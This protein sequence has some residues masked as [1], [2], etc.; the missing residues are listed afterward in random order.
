MG[1]WSSRRSGGR[2]LPLLDDR[3]LATRARGDRSSNKRASSLRIALRL[4][5]TPARRPCCSATAIWPSPQG[6]LTGRS[7]SPRQPGTR[8][9]RGGRA[10]T[11][12]AGP[13]CPRPEH[14]HKQGRR[15]QTRT[16]ALAHEPSVTVPLVAGIRPGSPR[17]CAARPA[18]QR[19]RRELLPAAE[20][21]ATPPSARPA[22]RSP[23]R[24]SPA[25]AGCGASLIAPWSAP[26]SRPRACPAQPDQ[27][28]EVRRWPSR[29]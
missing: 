17:G 10:P 16:A 1:R 24:W 7:S 29:S 5:R 13:G 19:A 2:A 25:R 27:P 3:L 20:P 21:T 26:T 15:A 14:R 18:G 4:R 9:T 11:S 12:P 28:A 22:T 23:A 8:R 6:K